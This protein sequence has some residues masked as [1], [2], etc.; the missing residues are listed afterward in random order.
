MDICHSAMFKHMLF[1]QDS[2][3]S[4]SFRWLHAAL[5]NH[6][7][8]VAR[9]PIQPQ[10]LTHLSDKRIEYM[11]GGY[12][13][14][15][16]VHAYLHTSIHSIPQPCS[17]QHISLL[18]RAFVQPQCHVSIWQKR[19]TLSSKRCETNVHARLPEAELRITSASRSSKTT[20]W[21]TSWTLSNRFI[22]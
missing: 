21:Y 12:G 20:S 1:L 17:A 16:G 8:G 5:Y 10:G 9:Q 6:D 19:L 15:E 22:F 2:L 7:P 18:S 13:F 14:H 11:D 4:E 3:S